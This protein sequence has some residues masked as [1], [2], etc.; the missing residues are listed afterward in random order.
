MYCNRPLSQLFSRY[1]GDGWIA[2]PEQLRNLEKYGN[3]DRFLRAFSAIKRDAKQSLAAALQPTA[4]FA[5]DDAMLFDVQVGKIHVN[6]RQL[7]HV[8]YLL[9]CYLAI[10]KGETPCVPRLHIFGGK[11]SPSDFL[12][13]Q[14]IHLI[15]AVA[16]RINSDETANKLLKVV[17]IPNATLSWAERIAP[18]VDLSEQLSTAGMEPAGTFSMKLAMN[19]SVTIASRSGANLELASRI[20]KEHIVTFGHDLESL[21]GLQDYRPTELLARDE[22]LKAIF[23]YLESELIPRT[24][25]GHAIL[26]L[27]SALRDS[28]RRYV[29]L[30]FNDYVA[31]QKTIDALYG[32]PGA[33]LKTS[34][35]NIA[36]IGWFTSDRLVREYVRDIWK[37]PVV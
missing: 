1:I 35:T 28:D 8:L 37:V 16:D 13:K 6:K 27:L 4:G 14:I 25:D 31:G 23:S 24:V 9:H 12:A 34:L 2:D 3:D 15:W 21:A 32:D 30:D 26:P 18:A 29:L 17:F 20:G 5:I 10:R 33:W 7:L 22:R 19:G 11:A 36:R